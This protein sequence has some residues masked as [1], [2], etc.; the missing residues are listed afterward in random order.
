MSA[1]TYRARAPL[2]KHD[3]AAD[4]P[5]G[6]VQADNTRRGV[7]AEQITN[8]YIGSTATK[9]VNE[10]EISKLLLTAMNTQSRQYFDPVMASLQ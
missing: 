4:C 10:T 5:R 7:L 2:R 9:E 8:Y 1:P 3:R 6:K